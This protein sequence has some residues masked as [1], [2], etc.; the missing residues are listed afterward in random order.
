MRF[1][2]AALIFWKVAASIAQSPEVPHKLH[3][4]GMTLTLR[5]DARREIQDDVDALTRNPRY[6]DV[7]VDRARQYFPI[8]ERILRE[9]RVPDEFKYLAL[10]ESALIADAV[11]VSNAV[12]YWQFKDFTAR[13][14][15]LRVDEV[16][17]ERKNIV[18][19][20]RGAARYLK[21]NNFIFNNWVL[22]LQSYQM[23]AGGVK[24]AVGNEFDG[25]RHMHITAATY[26]YIKK[27]LAHLV[28]FSHALQTPKEVPALREIVVDR[29]KDVAA[30]AAELALDPQLVG[31]H[32]KWILAASIPADKPY[33]VVWPDVVANPITEPSVVMADSKRLQKEEP[34]N[35]PV[36]AAPVMV[37]GVSG[38]A[39]RAGETL[40]QLVTRSGVE[41]SDFLDY[42]DIEI[43]HVPRLGVVY[44]TEKKNSQ[45]PEAQ[46][47]LA[48]GE[49][50][51]VVSQKY[52]VQLKRLR[53]YNR[54]KVLENLQA[55][56]V[57][58]LATNRPRNSDASASDEVL[59]LD[60]SSWITL[61]ETSSTPHSWAAIAE[62]ATVHVVQ[63][64]DT[65]YSI[66]RQYGVTVQ[67][68]M[69]WNKKQDG[70]LALG[71][72]IKIQVR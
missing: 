53:K 50:L 39:A 59:E 65:L 66:A 32:N 3:F 33:T 29:P 67:E 19:A 48:A 52:A 5:E 34:K 43:D 14:M 56:E 72:Q 36:M 54:S 69:A 23:G 2:A 6:F 16:I 63:K 31:T 18:S 51:W 12:G 62:N 22:A 9:E 57:I 13:E 27:Y 26:W 11:S 41:L 20:T 64:S 21:Q 30:L 71:E 42:N 68:L 44:F 4:A 17:D 25:E 37:N 58:W 45:A 60:E 55:G 8:I 49:D 61:G 1:F 46:H 10:Q 15:G 38:L 40:P 47:A 24:R 35:E 7:K 70:S 28:A